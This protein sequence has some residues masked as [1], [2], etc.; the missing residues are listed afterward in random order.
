VSCHICGCQETALWSH[1]PGSTLGPQACAAEPSSA[2]LYGNQCVVYSEGIPLIWF[3]EPSSW[4]MK[5]LSLLDSR[6]ELPVWSRRGLRI[7]FPGDCVF[8]EIF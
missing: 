7:V 3:E 8:T 1:S 4:L 6:P 5:L 2:V